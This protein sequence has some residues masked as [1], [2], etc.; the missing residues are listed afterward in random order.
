MQTDFPI[1]EAKRDISWDSLGDRQLCDS[2]LGRLAAHLGHGMTNAER[3][4]ILRAELNPPL[5]DE[6]WLC[7]GLV[8]E[9]DKFSDLV[10]NEFA[11]WEFKTFLIGSRVAPD[12]AARE[13]ELWTAVGSLHAEPIKGEINREVGKRIES[14]TDKVVDFEHPDVVAV[15]E[16]AFDV[17]NLQVN[18][19]FIAGRYMKLVR[20]IPQTR[21][22]C[23]KCLGKGCEHCGGKGKMYETSVEEVIA[24][25][26]MEQSGGDGHALHGMGREDVDARMLGKGRPFIVEIEHPKRRSV[27]LQKVEEKVNGSGIV[28]VSNLSFTGREEIVRLK[29]AVFDK[30]Y[31]LLVRLDS[32]V[33]EEKVKEGLASLL[34][35]PVAQRTPLRVSHR[36]ADKVRERRIRSIDAKKVDD[37]ILELIVRAEAGSYVKELINGDQGRTEPS[38]AGALGVGCEVLEL[39]VLEVHDGE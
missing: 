26:V 25:V 12:V 36:R 32:P 28:E 10:M 27:D 1:D 15:V 6:C 9:I 17:V 5:P 8:D 21:W 14:R 29:E 4:R 31:R 16:T 7:K 11:G 35:T 19:L 23:R 2:C 24:A 13:E 38:L 39:D 18:P 20:G 37:A 34:A 22:P 3:G 33:N 30:T